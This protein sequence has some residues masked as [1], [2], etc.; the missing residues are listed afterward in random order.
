MKSCISIFQ[1]YLKLFQSTAILY[2]KRMTT[3]HEKRAEQPDFCIEKRKISLKFEGNEIL[4]SY[5]NKISPKPCKYPRE[6]HAFQLLLNFSEML[7]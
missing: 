7:F 1:L 2:L 5:S 6:F 3:K 4:K